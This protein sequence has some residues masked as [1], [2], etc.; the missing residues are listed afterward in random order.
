MRFWYRR[1]SRARRNGMYGI[2]SVRNTTDATKPASTSR[3]LPATTP[4][5]ATTNTEAAV[6][7]PFTMPSP[8]WMTTPAPMKP[9]PVMTPATALGACLPTL[10]VTAAAPTATS[11]NGRSDADAPRIPRSMPSGRASP[12]AVSTLAMRSASD[13]AAAMGRWPRP[14]LP[15]PFGQ[16]DV[17]LV[18]VGALHR[19]AQSAAHLG[20]D[21]SIAE[22]GRGLD[23]GGAEA[24][25]VRRLEDARTDEHRFGAQL[26]HQ[27]GVGRGGDPA[28]AE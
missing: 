9:T 1:V 24:G 5:Q 19:I 14:G 17:Q 27:G 8:A 10:A 2:S 26:Q 20:H 3:P 21:R 16:L 7:I 22:V 18:D 13:G 28:G 23:D 11:T 6:V 4:M 12:A 25:R 15:A